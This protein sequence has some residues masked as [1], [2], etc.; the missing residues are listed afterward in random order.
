MMPDRGCANEMRT[1]R[2]AI[3]LCVTVSSADVNAAVDNY[4]LAAAGVG[5]AAGG[6]AS[7]LAIGGPLL[8]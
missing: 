7:A 3:A 6:G 5:A 1:R 8:T 2:S 4:F